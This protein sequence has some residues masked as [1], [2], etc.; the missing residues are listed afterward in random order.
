[1]NCGPSDFPLF[2]I[3]LNRVRHGKKVSVAKTKLRLGL[4]V[5]CYVTGSNFGGKF[6]VRGGSH[7]TFGI[8]DFESR[9]WAAVSQEC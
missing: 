8:A 1:M 6:R 4:I 7:V 5:L 3:C 9:V 2:P